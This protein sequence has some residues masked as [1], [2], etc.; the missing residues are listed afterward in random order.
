MACI[1]PVF[2]KAIF[3]LTIFGLVWHSTNAVG[4]DVVS[5]PLYLYASPTTEQYM[6]T[7]GQSYERIVK[8]WR[9]YLIKY[10][11]EAKKITR[12]QLLA[13]LPKGV[14]ILP[15]AIA[16]D[17]EE[18]SAIESFSASGGSLLGSGAVATRDSQG[19]DTGLAFLERTFRVRTHGFYPA[20]DDSFFMPFGDGPVTWPIPA[21]RRMP[22]ANSQDSILRISSANGAAVVMDW[23]RT[24][25]TSPH[26]VMAFD[27]TSNSRVAY[28]SMPDN[29]WPN[30]KDANLVLDATLAWLR[31]EPQAYK[32]AWPNGYTAA[33]LIEMDTEDQFHSAPNFAK[34][35]ES[36]GFKGTFYC[37]TSEAARYPNIVR[38]LIARGH[39]IGYHADVHYGFRG[40]PAG[41]Q[42]L[43]I[44]FMKQ[45]MQAIL[46]NRLAE[47]TGFRAPTESYDRN[48]E[49]LL[50]KHGVLHHAADESAH[51]DR[52][53]FFSLS[54]PG[55]GPDQALVVLPRTQYDDVSYKALKYTPE[56]VLATL[57][58]DL[59]LFVRSGA[60]GLLSVH[61]QNYVTGG[62]MLRTMR[63]YMRKVAS[64]RKQLWVARGDEITTWWRQREMVQVDQQWARN[65]L[66]IRLQASQAVSGLSVFI[67]LPSKN[68]AI[69]VLPEKGAPAPH[70]RVIDDF[71]SAL[72][73]DRLE[74]G[75][76]QVTLTF[77]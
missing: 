4:Q 10:A 58:Y 6:K 39:E 73:F 76:A 29:A 35:L 77:N 40:D 19:K 43:R 69:R 63:D 36:E 21:A 37:L 66:H 71:R 20:S 48:T 61:S 62:L 52:L 59:D 32:A 9:P 49:I 7:N 13:G 51:E 22:I 16:L 33:H 30:N 15:T 12:A 55:L 60:F 2:R 45:Q 46:G 11:D 27:E 14:L 50:R 18:R 5:M 67:T 53:P 56:Q 70:V 44:R 3:L 65:A 68:A 75:S 17:S 57:Y 34:D 64:Y 38:D 28:F 25:Q 31:R 47:A 42:E 74:A 72:V 23:S 24:K 41:E 54:E 1:T 26:D 8:R